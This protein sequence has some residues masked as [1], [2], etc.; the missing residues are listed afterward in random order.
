MDGIDRLLTERRSV[1]EFTAAALPEGDLRAALEA[2]VWAPNHRR[3]EPWRFVFARGEAQRNLA[4]CA[5]RLKQASHPRPESP[6]A[7]S[8]GE[9][10]RAEME[11][12]AA[13]L[14]VVQRVA[15]DRFI[16]EEDYAAC[17]LAADHALLAL[18]ARGIGGRWNTGG[19]TRDAEAHRILGIEAGERLVVLCPLGVPAQVPPR[20]APQAAADRTT[21]LS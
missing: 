20:P 10:A 1:R 4:A 11:N 8:V 18:W 6:E 17:V 2:A 21:W 16:A 12:A 5:G 3:T 15:S 14:V 19:V 13:L 9:R 7:A